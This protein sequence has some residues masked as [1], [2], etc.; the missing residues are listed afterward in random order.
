MEKI[1]SFATFDVLYNA[2]QE[3]NELQGEPKNHTSPE[4]NNCQNDDELYP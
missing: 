4:F 2:S 1:D 3:Q